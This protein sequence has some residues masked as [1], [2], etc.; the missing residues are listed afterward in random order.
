MVF[1]QNKREVNFF[2]DY[3]GFGLY[4]KTELKGKYCQA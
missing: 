3:S 2:R 4:C 1:F